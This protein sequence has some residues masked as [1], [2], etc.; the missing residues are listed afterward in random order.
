MTTYRDIYLA[1]DLYNVNPEQALDSEA[2]KAALSDKTRVSHLAS[3]SKVRAEV[4]LVDL[5]E[6]TTQLNE[7]K[8]LYHALAGLKDQLR[9]G[10]K[11][12]LNS[13]LRVLLTRLEKV[14]ENIN[15]GM[16]GTIN[17]ISQEITSE[18]K[19]QIKR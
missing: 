19:A 18:M 2:R 13:S 8:E 6:F 15:K 3:Y 14:D 5:N 12:K 9:P 1:M 7:V 17:E 10:D 11:D 16:P 4:G